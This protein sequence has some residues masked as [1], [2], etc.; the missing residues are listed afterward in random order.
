MNK[1]ESQKQ[2]RTFMVTCFIT[3]SR[4]KSLGKDYFIKGSRIIG[5]PHGAKITLFK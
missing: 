3:K 1:R 4:Y 5:Y 2:T